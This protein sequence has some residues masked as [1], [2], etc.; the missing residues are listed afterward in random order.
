[1]TVYFLQ[2][3]YPMKLLEEAATLAQTLDRNELLKDKIK[4]ELDKEE[5]ILLI[6][7]YNPNFHD[8]RQIVFNN[9]EMLGKS[10]ATDFLFERKLMCGYRRPKNLRDHVVRAEISYKEGDER[11]IGEQP[12]P[13]PA[14]DQHLEIT[15]ADLTSGRGASEI[16]RPLNLEVKKSLKQKSI[17]DFLIPVLTNVN[18]TN[19]GPDAMAQGT[20]SDTGIPQGPKAESSTKMG[21][22]T[23]IARKNRGFNFCNRIPCRYC[24]LLNKTG[25]IKS[26]VTGK[27]FPTMKNI[28]CRSSNVIYC[29]TCKRC[30][31]QYV[32][33]TYLR[34][35][36]RFVHHFYT[37]EKPNKSVPVGKHFSALDH[38]GIDDMDIHV[39]EFIK[40]PPKSE[41]AS[42][43]RD[44]VEKR[45]I[46]LLRTPAPGG[47][48]IED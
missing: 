21:G 48:N 13:T 4:S 19:T 35:K 44:R 9:W 47:L 32:G 36:G 28:S 8:L 42:A 16:S 22:T 40:K 18:I 30:R 45:W 12:A 39:L 14:T 27:S 25:E 26:T 43:I 1:M 20:S 29:I 10:P 37:V 33:Q 17:L 5:K 6:T 3:D 38:K 31:K 46:H 41:A 34:L 15:D 7:T 23:L 24:P 2:R 11:A